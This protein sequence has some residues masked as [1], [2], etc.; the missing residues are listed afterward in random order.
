MVKSIASLNPTRSGGF[1]L[2]L[3][4]VKRK[5]LVVIFGITFSL[6]NL[7]NQVK[8]FMCS[9]IIINF[10][11]KTQWICYSGLK[12]PMTSQT[13]TERRATY[14]TLSILKSQHLMS[15]HSPESGFE[16]A[17]KLTRTTDTS[18]SPCVTWHAKPRH[19]SHWVQIRAKISIFIKTLLKCG[20]QSVIKL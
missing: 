3:L 17:D 1:K 2:R 4:R 5:N 14:Q 7:S 8:D 9:K 10:E 16:Q 11:Q 19:H 15:L 18:I 12:C 6:W 13:M 20:Y